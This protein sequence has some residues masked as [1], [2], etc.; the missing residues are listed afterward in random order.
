M[1]VAGPPA[2]FPFLGAGNVAATQ[3]AGSERRGKPGTLRAAARLSLR[4]DPP[5]LAAPWDGKRARPSIFRVIQ[6]TVLRFFR[7]LFFAHP[8]GFLSTSLPRNIVRVLLMFLRK[9]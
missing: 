3:L 5:A 4:E 6:E 8:S 1:D 9:S 7:M 2:R